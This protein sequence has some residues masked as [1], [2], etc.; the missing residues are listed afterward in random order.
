MRIRFFGVAATVILVSLVLIGVNASPAG[1]GAPN[2]F[3][4]SG[5]TAA[6][7]PNDALFTPQDFENAAASHANA[8]NQIYF[9]RCRFA[10]FGGDANFY[11]PFTGNVS[12]AIVGDV[13]YD[14]PDGTQCYAPQNETNLVIDPSNPNHLVASA[15][16][17]FRNDG[18]I[19]FSSFD[20]G[21]TW[22]NSVLHGWT[23]DTGGQGVFSRLFTCGDPSVAVAPDGTVYSAGLVCNT[24]QV[25]FFSGVVV[26][27]SHDGGITWGA[28]VMVSFSN[29]V[30]N[31]KEWITVGPD[32]TVYVAWARFKL[33]QRAPYYAQSPIV[34]SKSTDG[35]QTWSAYVQVS[36]RSHPYNQG[37][38]PIVAP[39]GSLYIAY[40]GATPSSGYS[41]DAVLLAH[42]TDGGASFTNA[43]LAR[44]YDDYSNCYPFNFLGEQTLSGE[45]FRMNSLP[46]FA[47]DPSNEHMAIA[48]TDDQANPRCGYEKG[49]SFAGSS[50]NQVKLITSTDGSHWSVPLVLTSGPS[51]KVFPAVAANAG[52]IAVFYYTRAFSP[53]T[54]DCR[55]ALLDTT[56]NAISIVGGPVCLDFAMVSSTDGFAT[57]T[58]LTNQSSNPF[59]QASGAFI[60]DYTGAAMDAA[61]QAYAAWADSR[62]NPGI[63]TPTQD[64]DVAF[65]Q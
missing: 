30:L 63:T 44:V 54:D 43:E 3:R 13:T 29:A 38:V 41:G 52:R 34:V 58:R 51:D 17:G 22:I 5:A 50:S 12:D 31:D 15:N 35:G 45:Q 9:S 49:G 8:D 36:D 26:A 37:A 25:A 24:N 62:G 4:P 55:A 19:V 65:G 53:A 21:R 18:P 64:I 2:H 7:D 33:L 46:S 40:E 32:G 59:V 47:I 39:D 6:G 1:A 48:W 28:P 20:G 42:S 60:G 61:G 16:E 11:G 10:P 56:T 14:Y 57:E 23:Y 27:A